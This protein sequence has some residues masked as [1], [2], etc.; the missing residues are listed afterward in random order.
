M[1]TGT[2]S[3]R[4]RATTRQGKEKGS[5]TSYAA[6]PPCGCGL[7]NPRMNQFFGS[8]DSPQATAVRTSSAAKLQIHAA[9]PSHTAMLERKTLRSKI[10]RPARLGRKKDRQHWQGHALLTS[11]THSA[12]GLDIQYSRF[13]GTT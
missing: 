4:R 10:R 2:P 9:Y 6:F 11:R 13:L 7:S 1:S 8:S 12:L 3:L 5:H